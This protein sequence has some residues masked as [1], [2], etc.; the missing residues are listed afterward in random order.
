MVPPCV[1]DVRPGH[2]VLD[3]LSSPSPET[4]PNP[5]TNPKLHPEPNPNPKPDQV[6]DICAAPGSKTGQI[7]E[8]PRPPST[9]DYALHLP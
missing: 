1:L 5:E 2:V 7:L 8:A 4:K 6:L 9:L 3:G